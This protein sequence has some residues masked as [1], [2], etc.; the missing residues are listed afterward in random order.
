MPMP[1]V[2]YEIDDEMRR[3]MQRH[4]AWWRGHGLLVARVPSAP[5]ADLWLP[6]ANGTLATEDVDVQPETLDL[7]RLAG[8]PQSPG[9]LERDGDRIRTQSA[10]M[11]VPWVGHLPDPPH[12]GGAMRAHASTGPMEGASSTAGRLAATVDLRRLARQR[13][14]R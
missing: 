9:P 7:A 6:L 12:Q 1:R 4:E 3:L 13:L 10:F 11:R 14:L 8:E 2:E 5:L